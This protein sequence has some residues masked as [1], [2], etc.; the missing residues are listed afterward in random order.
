MG[1]FDRARGKLKTPFREG[2]S[3][4]MQLTWKSLPE[5]KKNQLRRVL[6]DSDHDGV[7]DKFDC[8]PFNPRRQDDMSDEDV[9]RSLE[10]N[11]RYANME[12]Y[13]Y[14]RR[15]NRRGGQYL[16][17]GIGSAGEQTQAR[18]YRSNPEKVPEEW[19]ADRSRMSRQEE[20]RAVDETMKG[21]PRMTKD[22]WTG[23]WR[24]KKEGDWW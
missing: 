11:D 7:P 1:F 14:A 17:P 2:A 22:V 6:K 21:A 19:L 24:G 20:Q 18:F 9:L 4:R 12:D 15:M 10:A 13:D 3:V 5:W 8:R 23:Q 16:S